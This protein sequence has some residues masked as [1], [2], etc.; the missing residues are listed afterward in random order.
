MTLI[1]IITNAF[2][3][4]NQHKKKLAKSL[5]VPI[6][7]LAILEFLN[8]GAEEGNDQIISGIL[9]LFIYCLIA[10]ITHRVIIIGPESVPTWGLFKPTSRE[11]SFLIHF[12]AISLFL[13]PFAL[14]L[15][16]IPNTPI[17]LTVPVFSIIYVY[18]ISRI[19][20]VFPA[21]AVDSGWGFSD[22]W[23]ATQKYQMVMLG[24]V[25]V[26]PLAIS[27]LSL[28]VKLLLKS[29]L[30]DIVFS[31]LGTILMVAALSSVYIYISENEKI[32]IT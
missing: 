27:G 16:A 15:L 30:M 17:S 24:V 18:L 3:S 14:L 20:L 25:L 13:T 2:R 12:V 5:L 28:L 26:F 19:S 32:F 4:L 6:I 11:V 9:D 10:I 1:H 23:Q 7:I 21:I 29:V 31:I 8:T 22:S